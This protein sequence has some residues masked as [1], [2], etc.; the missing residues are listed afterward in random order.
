MAITLKV[1]TV[2]NSVGVILPKEALAKL[3]VKKGDSLVLTESSEGMM[4][5]P[6]DPKFARAMDAFDRVRRRYRN[7]L[8]ELAK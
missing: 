2:G 6:Y 5:T 4:I 3:R 8:R 1:T 7:A